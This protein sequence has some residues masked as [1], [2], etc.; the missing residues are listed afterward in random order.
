M[1]HDLVMYYGAVN[2]VERGGNGILDLLKEY[3]ESGG[4]RI[5][6][7]NALLTTL[8]GFAA[9]LLKGTPAHMLASIG[10]V[11]VYLLPFALEAK[12]EFSNIS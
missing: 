9:M 2:Y 10:G 5:L 6:F 3:V 8:V 7:G 12:N 1:F 4:S 11:A